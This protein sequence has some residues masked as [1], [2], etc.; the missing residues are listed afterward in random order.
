MT[1]LFLLFEFLFCFRQKCWR[2]R[3]MV[4]D[5]LWWCGQRQRLHGRWCRWPWWICLH[6]KWWMIQLLM[7]RRC[8]RHGSRVGNSGRCRYIIWRIVG[9]V[10]VAIVVCWERRRWT[11]W[12]PRF[13]DRCVGHGVDCIATRTRIAWRCC[14]SGSV[15]CALLFIVRG[16]CHRMSRTIWRK[17]GS[18]FSSQFNSMLRF[19]TLAV[20][21][22][23]LL[24]RSVWMPSM[25]S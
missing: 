16:R 2:C 23:L 24:L 4:G 8:R 5:R 7:V 21:R 22:H 6:L 1:L 18:L 17:T 9:I 11:A 19:F 12:R 25:A 10:V 15:W 3:W 13:W 14:S 20:P